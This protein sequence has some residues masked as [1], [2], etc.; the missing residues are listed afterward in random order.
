MCEVWIGAKRVVC[1]IICS[2]LLLLSY[3]K[4][5][6]QIEDNLSELENFL[7][8]GQ[9][10]TDL[11]IFITQAKRCLRHFKFAQIGDVCGD[12]NA[13][14]P[15]YVECHPYRDTDLVCRLVT[16]VVDGISELM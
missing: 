11:G 10:T 6:E 3:T 4:K 2:F 9:C 15:V 14:I 8:Q 1:I 12:V 7:T 16:S 13:L 5:M